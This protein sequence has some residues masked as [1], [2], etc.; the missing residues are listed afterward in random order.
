MWART[1]TAPPTLASVLPAVGTTKGGNKTTI[2]GTALLGAT[3]FIGGKKA[4]VVSG[5]SAALTVL[6]PAHKIGKVSI[7]VTTVGG[8]A[9]KA[10]AYTYKK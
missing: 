1:W 6:V 4:R 8:S 7:T 5:T 3:V 9:S 10:K 2:K